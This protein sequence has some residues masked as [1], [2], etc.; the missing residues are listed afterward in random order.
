MRRV[1]LLTALVL[2]PHPAVAQSARQPYA[3]VND[4][5]HVSATISRSRQFDIVSR[6][7]GLTYRIVVY[8]PPVSGERVPLPVIYVL[9]GNQYF[10]VATDVMRRLSDNGS[11]V[12]IAPAIVVGIGYPSEDYPDWT[13]RR[14][15]DMT[16]WPCRSTD[17][18]TRSGGAELFFRTIEED[19]KP[20]VAAR[21]Q[22][23]RTQ[24][25]LYGHSLGGLFALG[26]MFNYPGT[27]TTYLVS[28]PSIWCNNKQILAG[29]ERF[30]REAHSR[31]LHLKVLLTSAG[32]E[33]YRGEDPAQLAS[34]Q[35]RAMVDNASHL[36]ERLSRLPVESVVVYRVI[37][38][39][40]N[41]G[42]VPFSSLTR[43]MGFAFPGQIV[44]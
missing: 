29:E 1:L 2:F 30:S 15:L 18:P 6:A 22:I 42:S 25:V 13:G 7:N 10:G 32:D 31:Q 19:I 35:Q 11:P 4:S 24:Q 33:Q 43:G 38:E 37:F 21:Y 23:D 17:D 28:S 27:F 41:H 26:V 20:L 8:E 34:A 36:A 5:G 39:G 16:P 14:T 3:S 12:V 44:R 9:D 40:E